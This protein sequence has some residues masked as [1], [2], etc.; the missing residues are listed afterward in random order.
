MLSC[1]RLMSRA[2]IAGY[3]A[4][5]IAV[6]MVAGCADEVVAPDPAAEPQALVVT[7][8]MS[9][10]ALALGEDYSCLRRTDGT[11]LC[12]GKN[13]WGQATAP[14]TLGTVLNVAA[15]FDHSCALRT[16]GAVVCWGGPIGTRVPGT[17]GPAK[18]VVTGYT[19]SCAIKADDTVQCWGDATGLPGDMGPVKQLAVN[20]FTFCAIRIDDSVRC[21]GP[22][23]AFGQNSAPGD[24]GTVK[25]IAAGRRNACAVKTDDTLVCWGDNTYGQNSPPVDLGTVKMVAA[26]LAHICAIK[27]DDTLACW[28]YNPRRQTDVPE[29]LGTVQSIAA[30]TNHNCAIKTDGTVACWG[31]DN[32]YGQATVPN[33]S[34]RYAPSATFTAPRR[35]I[36]GEN[37]DLA[38]SAAGVVTSGNTISAADAGIEYAYDCDG[39]GY[40][41]FSGSATM[42]C[43]AGAAG[44]ILVKGKVRD[45]DGD[46]TEYSGWVAVAPLAPGSAM[47]TVE[48]ATS[49]RID[50]TDVSDETRFVL[51][52]RQ[53]D[54]TSWSAFTEIGELGQNVTTY[55]AGSLTPGMRYQFRVR[56]CVNVCSNP[57]MTARIRLPGRL[58]DAR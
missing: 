28:G 13:D 39:L 33:T 34:A 16:G 53:S 30:G 10:S 58:A 20:T 37:F 41:A 32:V 43:L 5:T 52:S 49:I 15:G 47:A 6:M 48:D 12:W 31:G 45:L 7:T 57:A 56:A 11:I 21:W 4:A 25:Q 1:C 42:S 46:E 29:G 22:D 19:R 36:T 38:L 8:N 24:L 51:Y 17:L 35:V 55:V 9:A 14:N 23:N 26:G 40:S 50:W 44:R 3:A 18:Q 54:G 27:T 2:R